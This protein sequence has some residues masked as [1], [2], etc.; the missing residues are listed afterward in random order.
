LDH[1][2]LD[3]KP[4]GLARQTVRYIHTVVGRALA[5]AV[6]RGR[7]CATQPE[8]RRRPGQRKSR[9]RRPRCRPGMRPRSAGS[10]MPSAARRGEA[11]RPGAPGTTSRSCSWPRLGAGAARP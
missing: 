6:R 3:G 4:G 10:S 8:R 5:D 9:R 11:R 7:I 1:G 2:R